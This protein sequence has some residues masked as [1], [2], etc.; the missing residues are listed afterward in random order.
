MT[1]ASP[2]RNAEFAFAG[3]MRASDREQL[4]AQVMASVWDTML[5]LPLLVRPTDQAEDF[6]PGCGPVVSGSI[7]IAGS[8][9]GR[10][11]LVAPRTFAA[12]CTALMLECPVEGLSDADVG[13]AWGELVNMVGGHLKA[14]VPPVSTLGLPAVLELSD[15]RSPVRGTP[16]GGANRVTFA[17]LG[18]RVVLMVEHA[19]A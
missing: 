13:D 16:A 17:C 4:L 7:G 6:N 11:T 10:V 8:W 2:A 5:E 19:Q 1:T 14:L 3:R 12:K 9:E 15:D 18:E